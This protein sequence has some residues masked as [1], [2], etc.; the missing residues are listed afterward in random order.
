MALSVAKFRQA[1]AGTFFSLSLNLTRNGPSTQK[2]HQRAATRKNIRK[3][4]KSR[5]N[6]RK[7]NV[8][9]KYLLFRRH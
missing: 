7:K 3:E 4:K 8:L 2:F 9:H 1:F 5:R 6:T